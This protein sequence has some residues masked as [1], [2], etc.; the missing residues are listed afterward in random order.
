[1]IRFCCK[2]QTETERY[3]DGVCKPCKAKYRAANREKARDSVAKWRAANR[4]KKRE[5][6]TRYCA[7]NS[8]ARRK[9]Q[10][11]YQAANLEKYRMQSHSR[12][13]RKRAAGGRLS[14][15]LSA[16]LFKLQRGKCACC[17]LPLGDD[18][19]LDHIMPLA[20]G[21]TNTDN[22]MQ[23]L[24]AICNHQKYTKHPIDFMQQRGFLL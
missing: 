19:H 5:Y 4:D 6:D 14:P 13:A 8:E 7:A 16:R 18:Y 3:G 12:R 21:G 11:A 9:Y 20:L 15:D 24:R 22:N 17:G 1:M 23:L 10:S 2:C